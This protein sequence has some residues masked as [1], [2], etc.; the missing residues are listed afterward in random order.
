[1]SEMAFM[2]LTTT[3]ETLPYEQ[4]LKLFSVLANIIGN[5]H[6]NKIN[7]DTMQK[8]EKLNSLVGIIPENIDVATE[9]T[10]RRAR[11]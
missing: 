5:H 1:M 9:Q 8:I 6:E 4:Q 10:L 7:N 2:Q 11:Q 3:V